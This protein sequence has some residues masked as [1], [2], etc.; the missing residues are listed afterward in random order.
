MK[1]IASVLSCVILFFACTRDEG[2]IIDGNSDNYNRTALLTNWADNIIIPSY[3]NYQAKVKEL[4][5]ATS[6]FT[7]AP[8]EENLKSLRNSWV[9]AYKAFQY[10][11]IYNVGKVEELSF[12]EC[13]N[14]Y[15]TDVNGIKSNIES[16]S[17]NLTLLSQFSKQ[18]FP[19]LDY[20]INGL[21]DSDATIVDFY[22]NNV[23]AANYKQ[24]ITALVNRLQTNA[25]VIVADWNSSFKSSFIANNGKTVTSSV[26]VV[27]NNFTKNLEKNIR[28]GKIGIPAG[29]FSANVLF[30]EK[31]EAYYKNDISKALLNESIKA[32]QDFFN[33]KHFNSTTTG[34]SLKSYLDY[35]NVVRSGEK[36]S[37]IINNQFTVIYN[38]NA[39][40]DNSLSKQVVN[41]NAKMI[42]AFDALQQNVLYIKLDMLQALSI[43]AD[44]VDADGD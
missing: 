3:I 8:S 27:V 12:V 2:E 24:Y 23:N 1:K 13:T 10:I 14:A 34:E 33:G 18:G 37:N 30:P 6:N 31:T 32:S 4:A 26:N 29:V 22:V 19:A 42:S 7:V 38:A 44:Y 21:S 15:P 20:L 9:D 43:K 11:S 17:Y 16:G 40:L 35:R 25:D 28:T 41:N 36:L 5:T 39:A